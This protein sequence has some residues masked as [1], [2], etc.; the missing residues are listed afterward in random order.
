MIVSL[1]ISV[2]IIGLACY[3]A[4]REVRHHELHKLRACFSDIHKHIE[5]I[6]TKKGAQDDPETMEILKGELIGI[7]KAMQVLNREDRDLFTEIKEDIT[8]IKE[9]LGI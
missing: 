5:E 1:I 3:V 6:E 8:K 2:I 7:E 9:K 4:F